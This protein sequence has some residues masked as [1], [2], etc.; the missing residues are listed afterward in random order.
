MTAAGRIAK[1]DTFSAMAAENSAL[2]VER[3]TMYNLI[4]RCRDWLK[5]MAAHPEKIDE[6][7]GI[8]RRV[9]KNPL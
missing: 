4:V 1:R 7:D 5:I 2:R 8:I 9:R 3:D 6:L